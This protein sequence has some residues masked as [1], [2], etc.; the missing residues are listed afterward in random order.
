MDTACLETERLERQERLD[1][2]RTARE[3]NK[4][5]QFATPPELA[6]EIA[7]YALGL[8]KE[9]EDRVRFLEPALGSGAFYSALRRTFS[10]DP[11]E[12]ATGVEMD[13]LFAATARSLWTRSGLDVIE[14][15]FTRQAPPEEAR[16]YNLILTNPPYVR[17]HHLSRDDKTRLQ[18]LVL[19][20]VHIRLNGLAG[21]YCYFLLLG[22]RWLAQDGLSIWLIPSEFMDVNYGEA[23]RAYLTHRVELLHVHRFS[24]QDVQFDDALVTSAVVVFRKRV[25]DADHGVKLSQGGTLLRPARTEIVPV[26]TLRRIDKWMNGSTAAPAQQAAARVPMGDLFTI[27]RGI[28]TGSNSFF[29][30]PFKE[31]VERGIPPRFLRPILP[32]AR[33]LEG[34]VIEAEED[35]SPK[36]DPRLVLLDCREP[37]ERLRSN[38]PAVWAYLEAGLARNIQEGYITRNRTLWYAQ[39]HRDPPP[40]LCTY[41]GRGRG[42]T[43]PFR[44]LWNR[45]SA[46]A[47]NVYLLLYPKGPLQRALTRHPELHEE[48]FAGLKDIKAN[49]LVSEG[50]VYGGGLYKLEPKELRRLPADSVLAAVR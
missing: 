37:E 3:R 42:G 22:D 20:D 2:Q 39:E 50:R 9:R 18:S 13:P 24:P 16:R 12:A 30:L 15:D 5:G 47:A 41:M 40:F 33:H 36:V 49:A 14:G 35:G 38:H 6:L 34:D 26:R 43:P 25:P 4:L 32:S 29:I 46:V 27:K 21:L 7:Q 11:I 8:W 19:K 45:S 10:A 17:H 31:A 44:F 48:V 1:A 28:A 23:V